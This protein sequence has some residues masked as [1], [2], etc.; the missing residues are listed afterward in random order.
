MSRKLIASLTMSGLALMGLAAPTVAFAGSN[1]C[2][3]NMVCLYDHAGFSGLLGYRAAGQ[4][5]MNVST[6]SNDRMTSW[7]NKSSSNAAW[8][9]DANGS[10]KCHTM[11]ARSENAE[12]GWW[13]KD[14]LSSWRTNGGC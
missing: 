14:T 12:V 4:S 10:G 3:S 11:A 5:T 1:L 6:P 8:Y 7:E 2:P 9:S 13:D